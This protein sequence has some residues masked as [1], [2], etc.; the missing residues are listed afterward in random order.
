M[1]LT[2]EKHT[3]PPRPRGSHYTYADYLEWDED[4]RAEI[5]NGEVYAMSPPLTVHQRI[6]RKLTIK[7]GTWLEGKTCELFPAPFGVRLSP[8]EDYSDDTVLEPDLVVICDS[9][10]IDERGCNGAP[11]LVIEI[12][13]PSNTNRD[14]LVKLNL[15]LDAGVR[16][17]WIVDPKNQ[18]V[19][20]YTLD[21][22][23][24]FMTA[25]GICD[26]NDPLSRFT[27][28]IAPVGVLPGLTI[29]LKTIFTG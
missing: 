22:G 25:Y 15:Y 18:Y 28:D 7:I 16:E 10:K 2:Q 24:Y 21:Q 11:D 17:Y 29:D 9:A 13:S 23:R 4:F 20:I 3:R 12:L 1:P 14:T 6:V 26:P 19:Q 8:K 5:I 27:Q